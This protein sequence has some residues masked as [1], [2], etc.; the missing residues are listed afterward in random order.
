MQRSNS[1]TDSPNSP[2]LWVLIHCTST[3]SPCCVEKGKPKSCNKNDRNT[4]LE[5]ASHL[6]PRRSNHLSKD[7]I[8]IFLVHIPSF[9][10]PNG[11]NAAICDMPAPISPLPSSKQKKLFSTLCRYTQLHS[12]P[13]LI[14]N[15][16]N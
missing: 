4:P 1:D 15:L 13:S 11:Q 5:I 2:K 8:Y 14:K 6:C 10:F 16:F 7:N 3:F 12:S 9:Q